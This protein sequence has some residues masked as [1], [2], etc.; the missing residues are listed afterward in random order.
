MTRQIVDD[1]KFDINLKGTIKEKV[2]RKK[3]NPLETF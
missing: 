1:Q 3:D 2:I